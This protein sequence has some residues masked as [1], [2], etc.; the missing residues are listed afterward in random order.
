MY[1]YIYIYIYTHV[2]RVTF[3]KYECLDYRRDIKNV[4]LLATCPF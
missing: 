4:W 1:V 2:D 3:W